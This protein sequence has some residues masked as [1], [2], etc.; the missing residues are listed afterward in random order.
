MHIASVDGADFLNQ[1][2]KAVCHILSGSVSC[3]LSIR[4]PGGRNNLL[5]LLTAIG[6]DIPGPLGIKAMFLA[7]G[8]DVLRQHPFVQTIPPLR[9]SLCLLHLVGIFQGLLISLTERQ[10]KGVDCSP[11]GTDKHPGQLGRVNQLAGSDEDFARCNHLLDAVLGQFDL[12]DAGVLAAL[13]P[14]RL[15][16]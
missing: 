6:P 14:F 2:I 1:V 5:S 16:W 11:A 13:G 10:I 7:Q 8:A 9:Q 4:S 3:Q 15:S 12:A